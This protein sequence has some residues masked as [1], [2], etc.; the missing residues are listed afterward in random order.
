M[1]TNIENERPKFDQIW[2]SMSEEDR[3]AHNPKLDSELSAIHSNGISIGIGVGLLA[4][5]TGTIIAKKLN[6]DNIGWVDAIG[7]MVGIATIVAGIK[8]SKHKIENAKKNAFA[9]D[10]ILTEEGYL[11]GIDC[12]KK[13]VAEATKEE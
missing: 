8:S 7:P 4:T 9:F 1:Y 2:D 12:A 10:G 13:V 11:Y 6:K 3:R 5:S